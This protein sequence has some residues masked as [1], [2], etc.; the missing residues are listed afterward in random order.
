MS[1]INISKE[2][3]TAFSNKDIDQLAKMFDENVSLKDW[4]VQAEGRS[5][6]L[7]VNQNIFRS[8]KSI[9]VKPLKLYHDG[10]TVIAELNIDINRGQENLS[11]VDVI[12]FSDTHLITHIRAYKG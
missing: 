8:V 11:V 4:D 3:F 1:L 6:V 2:Y 7:E 9:E 12:E 10:H 5:A